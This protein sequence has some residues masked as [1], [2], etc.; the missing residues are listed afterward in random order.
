MKVTFKFI[1]FFMVVTF[2][3]SLYLCWIDYHFIY[4]N[5]AM[6]PTTDTLTLIELTMI[7]SAMI[8]VV[9]WRFLHRY[10]KYIE[11]LQRGETLT[12]EERSRTM[13]CYSKA[14]WV[15]IVANALGFC[16]GK[17]VM[18]VLLISRFP[19]MNA[20]ALGNLTLGF[21]Q[22]FMIG[23]IAALYETFVLNIMM[24]KSRELLKIRH[25][26]EF[27]KGFH[28]S[29]TG[30]ILLIA[31]SSFIFIGCNTFLSPFFIISKQCEPMLPVYYEKGFEAFLFTFIP[32]TVLLVIITHS[33]KTRID[34]TSKLIRNL[35]EDGNLISRID[36]SEND[37]F[38]AL[39]GK[40][41]GFLDE[42]SQLVDNVQKESNRTAGIS[43]ELRESMEASRKVLDQMRISMQIV[44]QEKEQ[45]KEVITSATERVQKMSENSKRVASQV[46]IQS[47]ALSQSSAAVSQMVANIRSVTQMTERAN[48]YAAV[49]KN[50]TSMGT[51]SLSEA[52]RTVNE[53]QSVSTEIQSTMQ[54]IQK[55][56]SQTNI[57]SMNAA[58]EAAHAGS[59]GTGFAVVASEVRNLASSSAASA[60][61]IQ[62][63][64]KTMISKVNSGV[65]AINMAGK[66]FTSITEN[67][68]QTTTLISTIANTMEEQSQG[69]THTLDATKSLQAAVDEI[70][71]IARMQ[72]EATEAMA[73]SFQDIVASS[74][75][76]A[77]ALS[78]NEQ[79][80]T[81]LGKAIEMVGDKIDSS[82]KA[83]DTI[84]NLTGVFK[85]AENE[86]SVQGA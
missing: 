84:R 21:I 23:I 37:D 35:G 34:N 45:Q 16:I 11:R 24:T 55:I 63:L 10:D 59:F 9:L 30:K 18:T 68:N 36:I 6:W 65:A 86:A 28:I 4:G 25:T 78:E 29:V 26:T 7:L 57:L 39:H 2:I 61:T 76:V 41:N 40:L 66:S 56:A 27:G 44:S 60:K 32:C 47:D 46:N 69:A 73:V 71:H 48:E 31:I 51:T 85:L 58:I 54:V 38:A 53:I 67:I 15:I 62:G 77:D 12:Q 43:N 75:K 83:M 5:L 19:E 42:L 22:S 74:Q 33:T 1:L 79:D 82:A 20:K 3:A 13:D 72:S 52:V 49:L 81:D 80:S 50:S 17:I 8:A 70:K 64:I 14:V